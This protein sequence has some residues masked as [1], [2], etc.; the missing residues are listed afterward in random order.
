MQKCSNHVDKLK[1]LSIKHAKLFEV[2]LNQEILVNRIFWH[3]S[4]KRNIKK[5]IYL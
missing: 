3:M 4:Q 5:K 2:C 1:L